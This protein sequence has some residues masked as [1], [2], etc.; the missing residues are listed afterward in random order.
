MVVVMPVIWH[1]AVVPESTACTLNP[2]GNAGVSAAM[3]QP[4]A[5][6]LPPELANMTG[7]MFCP[8]LNMPVLNRAGVAGSVKSILAKLGT[9][10][11]TSGVVTSVGVV[12]LL[13]LPRP[14]WPLLPKPQQWSSPTVL[15]AQV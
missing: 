4:P 3:A 15:V 6:T 2:S 13:L 7:G 1:V 12:W 10:L 14:S 5:C 11:G 8:A 9:M